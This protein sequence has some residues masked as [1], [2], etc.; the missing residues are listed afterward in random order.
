GRYRVGRRI[1]LGG[2]GVVFEASC[3]FDGSKVAIKTLRP[4]FLN[5]ID[6]GHRLRREAEVAR[7]VAHPGIVKVIDTGTLQDGS[8]YVV[9]PLMFGESLARMLLR[10]TEL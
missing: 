7:R 5:H 2:T 6:L 9:M 4:C 8:P 3:T 10:L 1:G